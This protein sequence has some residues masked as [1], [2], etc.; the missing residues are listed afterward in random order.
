[1]SL[2]GGPD[3]PAPRVSGAGLAQP[4]VGGDRRA[5]GPREHLPL[6]LACVQDELLV[7]PGADAQLVLRGVEDVQEQVAL[8]GAAA[9]D[10]ACRHLLTKRRVTLPPLP[11]DLTVLGTSEVWFIKTSCPPRHKALWRRLILNRL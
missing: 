8:P 6:A 7:V 3:C 2:R 10:R 11:E 5:R 1:M 9:K 4:P